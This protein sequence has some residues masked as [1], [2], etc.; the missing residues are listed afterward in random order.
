MAR[1]RAKE[2]RLAAKR[3]PSA[4][5]LKPIKTNLGA[6]TRGNGAWK[7]HRLMAEVPFRGGDGLGRGLGVQS[8]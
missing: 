1:T 3:R 5:C 6:K 2:A 4:R 7:D 8:Q